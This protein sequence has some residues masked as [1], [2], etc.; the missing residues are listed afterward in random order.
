VSAIVESRYC[1]CGDPLTSPREIRLDKCA[2]CEH[3]DERMH[4]A[5]CEA[6]VGLAYCDG[7]PT[8]CSDACE[9]AYYAAPD[10]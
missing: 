10:P 9:D 5:N 8:F 4:C 6:Y 1:A 3:L 7:R 2:E